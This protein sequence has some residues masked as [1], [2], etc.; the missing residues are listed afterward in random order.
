MSL[1]FVLFFLLAFVAVA[2]ALTLILARE[3]IHSALALILV[4][5]SLAV[6][7]LCLLYTSGSAIRDLVSFASRFAG[8]TKYM[9]LGDYSNSRGAAD[10]GV[11]PDRLPG[12]APLSDRAERERF[13]KLWGGQI[14]DK[15]GLSAHAMMDAA[16][17][18]H[19]K[20]LYVVGANPL[21]SF[22]VAEPDPVSYTHLRNPEDFRIRLRSAHDDELFPP[23]RPRPRTASR[24][25]R[26]CEA[27]R[28]QPACPYRRVRN[29]AHEKQNLA[30]PH[31]GRR[32]LERH[33]RNRHGLYRSPA[34]CQRR[35]LRRCL[36]Y[37]SRCV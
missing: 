28:R 37:T 25:A 5:I 7:Y 23:G 32:Y 15:A 29:T 27:C 21:K 30:G 16:A 17:A 11:L 20:A 9:A 2:G 22:N 8:Q 14:S 36:L 34:S 6:L 4:M 18:G 33:R 26:A 3:P 12:Y 1:P 24:L 35:R 31:C 13:G 10:M 19:L